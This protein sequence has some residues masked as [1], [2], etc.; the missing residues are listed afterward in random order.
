MIKRLFTL[1][2]S[3]FLISC[4]DIELIETDIRYSDLPKE[5]KTHILKDDFYD[6]NKP[7]RF[8]LESRK[9]FLPWI[10]ETKLIRLEDNKSYK[11]DFDKE[12]SS[13]SLIISDD[14]LFTTSNYNVYIED[15]LKYTFKKYQIE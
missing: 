1:V 6:L 12:Y 3:I 14:Y 13:S 15:S 4:N 8:K 7:I 10:Y 11:I 2:L 5:V 9:T